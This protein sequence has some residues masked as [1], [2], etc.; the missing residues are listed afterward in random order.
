MRNLLSLFF[1]NT[2]SF[3][4]K[5]TPPS[6]IESFAKVFST[7]LYHIDFIRKKIVLRNLA[8]AFP[9]LS[10]QEQKE[11]AKKVYFNFT[12]YFS[13]VIKNIDISKEDLEKKVTIVGQKHIQ[14]AL[15]LQKPIVF[16]TAHFGNWEFA[17]KVI[18]A[19]YTPMLVLERKF[20]NP[21][22]AKI[23]QKNRNS[24][25]ITTINKKSS[26]REIIKAFKEGKAL[27]ILIDQH[28]KSK[29]AIEVDFFGKR[30]KFNRGV[31]TLAK[32][33]DAIVVPMFSYRKE[34]QYYLEFLEPK[35]FSKNDTLESFT[36][37]QA[38]TI[39]AMIKKYPDEYYWFHK[40]FKNIANIYD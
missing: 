12:L 10:K 19:F 6:K 39:E 8:I 38:S 22:I 23:F 9:N 29:T 36:Q 11:I 34:N 21:H 24:F 18:G 5:K 30:V 13:E 33:F 7:L 25:N 40:R 16:M 20:D 4:I 27:G 26:A 14:E 31:T 15:S 17:P 1:F 3:I 35:S 2:L 37:W 28:S 32:K